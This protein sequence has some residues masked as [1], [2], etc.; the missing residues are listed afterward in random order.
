VLNT[1]H[2]Y[3]PCCRRPMLLTLR[4]IPQMKP[5]KREREFI[6]SLKQGVKA[7]HGKKAKGVIKER[8]KR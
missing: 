7:A 3:T 2:L 8:H 4:G 6:D 5:T 1:A